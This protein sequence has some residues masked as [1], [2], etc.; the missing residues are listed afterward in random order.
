MSFQVLYHKL[1]VEKEI[2]D[3]PIAVKSRIKNAVEKK[4]VEYPE[5]FGKPL[6]H[7]LKGFR[8]LRVD[9]YRVVF[10]IEKNTVKIFMIAHR[11]TIYSANSIKALTARAKGL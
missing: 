6:R 11:S 9:D 4:L 1:V 2:S 3:L 10:R 7:S 5:I 8:R